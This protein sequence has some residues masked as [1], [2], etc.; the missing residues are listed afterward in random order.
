MRYITSNNG[1][2]PKFGNMVKKYTQTL[3]L[4]NSNRYFPYAINSSAAAQIILIFSEPTTVIVNWGNGK[5]ETFNTFVNINGANEFSVKRQASGQGTIP[6]GTFSS[7]GKD[8]GTAATRYITFEFDRLLLTELTLNSIVL[9][10]QTFSLPLAEYPALTKLNLAYLIQ[11]F[12]GSLVTNGSLREFNFSNISESLVDYLGINGVFLDSGTYNRILP[13]EIFELPLKTLAIGGNYQVNNFTVS[14]MNRIGTDL[15]NTLENLTMTIPFTQAQGLPSNFVNLV[16]L[17]SFT[18]A[19]ISTA[20]NW[21]SLPIVIQQM[22]WLQS[23]SFYSTYSLSFTSVG[24]DFS[25]FNNLIY[26]NFVRLISTVTNHSWINTLPTSIRTLDLRIFNNQ[27]N[28]NN[29]ITAIYNKVKTN[30]AYNGLIIM[31]ENIAGVL[32]AIPTGTY[33]SPAVIGSPQSPMECI[34]ELNNIYGCTVTYRA[35]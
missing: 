7:L 29:C 14:N 15:A 35:S 5:I 8:Y 13:P 34:W 17:K 20:L 32:S 3:S 1:I 19:N 30:S 31:L 11:T 25:N 26:L 18:I 28:L 33:Q 12:N 27:T 22:N 16:N 21:T 9:P 23:I 2:V 4:V 10:I 24:I 6:N